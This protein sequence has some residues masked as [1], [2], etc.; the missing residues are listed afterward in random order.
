MLRSPK[1]LALTKLDHKSEKG[2]VFSGTSVSF[3]PLLVVVSL[4]FFDD[5]LECLFHIISFKARSK[6]IL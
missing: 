6:N 1:L 3:V 5:Y 2:S 4:D